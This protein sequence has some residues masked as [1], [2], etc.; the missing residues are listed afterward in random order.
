MRLHDADCLSLLRREKLLQTL[1]FGRLLALEHVFKG[2]VVCL[3]VK[4]AERYDI[5]LAGEL[6]VP[7][8]TA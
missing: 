4:L 8:R 3:L 5:L 7:H 2:L 6:C 1:A